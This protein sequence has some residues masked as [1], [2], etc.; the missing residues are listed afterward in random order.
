LIPL[1]TIYRIAVHGRG[2]HAFKAD[3]LGKAAT[4]AEFVAVGALILRSSLIVPLAVIAATLGLV[5]VG[6]Y[7]V[8]S[9]SR[10]RSAAAS[11]QSA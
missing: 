6:H 9:R 3:A 11:C 5:A 4:I 8:R 10:A 2:R 1:A 7:I